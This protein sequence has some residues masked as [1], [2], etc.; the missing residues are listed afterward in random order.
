M[1]RSTWRNGFRALGRVPIALAVL[2]FLVLASCEG[3]SGV[4][5]SGALD[6]MAL[7]G[8]VEAD[9]QAQ[10][11][12]QGR[13]GANSF[14]GAFFDDGGEGEVRG[15]TENFFSAERECA[16]KTERR[17]IYTGE[18]GLEVKQV[19]SAI[20]LF[21]AH[22]ESVGG[23]MSSREDGALTCRVPSAEFTPTFDWLL[24]QGRVIGQSIKTDDVSEEWVDLEV[25]VGNARAARDRLLKL[26]ED[27]TAVNDILA[28]EKEL[29]RLTTE[30][31]RFEGR[32]KLLKDRVAMATITATFYKVA[33][34]SPKRG[35]ASQFPW[36]R[37]VWV[38]HVRRNF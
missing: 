32:L 1:K 17:L 29:Q 28:I 2:G 19:D 22:V 25:R 10:E 27:A 6:G 38:D 34:A 23:Y 35:R 37:T 36:V 13:I 7:D 31:E 15:R 9:S 11:W 18:V 3:M 26:L 14:P 8:L 4:E 24:Q 21:V 33:P 5:G 30:I 12:Q 16:A 20:A